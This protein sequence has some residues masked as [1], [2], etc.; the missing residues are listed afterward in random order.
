MSQK[1][2]MQR[3]HH[4]HQEEKNADKVVMYIFSALVA[5]AVI[6]AGVM[7]YMQS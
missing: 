6:T 3:A 1:R 4:A 7:I 2:K 5:L